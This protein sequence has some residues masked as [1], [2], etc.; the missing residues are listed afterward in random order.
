MARR[1]ARSAALPAQEPAG[2]TGP[3]AHLSSTQVAI[4]TI[5]VLIVIMAASALLFKPRFENP[6]AVLVEEPLAKDAAFQLKPGEHYT[7]GMAG[8]GTP[9]AV[10]YQVLAG[11]N[12]TM[13]A[14]MNAHPPSTACVR[15]DGTDARGYNSQ[16]ENADI[17]MYAP[18]MLA[19]R[20]GW[21]WNVSMYLSYNGTLAY[22]ASKD[23]R[24]VRVEDYR[25]RRAFV[26]AE[27]ITGS[28]PQY[29]WIDA[30]KRV[31][32]RLQCEGYAI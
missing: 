31:L 17:F 13:I 18:W 32:L 1:S 4:A 15:A 24:V 7:Y 27:N 6:Q 19:L 14:F 25:G 9:V 28:Q 5:A 3:L 30:E 11:R 21:R 8:N 2:G 22:V 12:C 23:Y 10:S 26:V 29:E 16:L 20:E